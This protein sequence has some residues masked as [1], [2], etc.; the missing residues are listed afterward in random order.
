MAEIRTAA[1]ILLGPGQQIR[2]VDIV[3]D[4]RKQEAH[5]DAC[6]LFLYIYEPVS[7]VI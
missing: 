6:L 3:N 4:F 5:K 7:M 1:T 2:E